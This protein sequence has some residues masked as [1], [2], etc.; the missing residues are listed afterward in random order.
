MA[1]SWTS[2]T[3]TGRIAVTAAGGKSSELTVRCD[4]LPADAVQFLV[5]SEIE[6]ARCF[7]VGNAPWYEGALIAAADLTAAAK[8]IRQ[9]DESLHD[10]VDTLIKDTFMLL[11]RQDGGL[12]GALLRVAAVM[13]EGAEKYAVDNWR[14]VPV[15]VHLNHAIR[16]LL[17]LAAGENAGQEEHL[18]HAQCRTIMALDVWL[19]DRGLDRMEFSAVCGD[20]EKGV[21]CAD[22]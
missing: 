7:A 15:D 14:H 19:C 12:P 17:L 16:H 11:A 9:S 2:Q 8:M 10:R 6:D 18:S 3:E 13:R 1:D 20:T 5:K 21:A 4:L 22:G